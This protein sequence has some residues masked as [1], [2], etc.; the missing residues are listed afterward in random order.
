MVHEE[1]QTST[2]ASQEIIEPADKDSTLMENLRGGEGER[3]S[4]LCVCEFW[5]GGRGK[6]GKG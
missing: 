2:E 4:S 6:Q 5:E 3:E 1:E